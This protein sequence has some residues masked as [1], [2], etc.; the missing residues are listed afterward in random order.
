MK[1]RECLARIKK[2]I[3][4]LES[5]NNIRLAFALMNR[6]MLMQQV[7]YELA[8]NSKKKREWKMIDGIFD[9]RGTM[10][11]RTTHIH[12]MGK[13]SGVPSSLLSFS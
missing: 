8:S 11:L 3:E 7:H 10:R 9:W 4:L 1:C 6:A 5:D 12:P 2:G 13:V